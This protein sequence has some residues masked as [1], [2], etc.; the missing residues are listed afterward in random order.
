GAPQGA[1][2][3]SRH[4]GGA[5][6]ARRRPRPYASEQ[7][8]RAGVSVILDGHVIVVRL[9]NWLGDTVMALPA[10]AALR[11]AR[12]DALVT[13]VGPSAPLLAGQAGGAA[14]PRRPQG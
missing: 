13:A 5:G 8:C 3:P 11:A 10:L 4:G 14:P 2:R 7:S 6:R 1:L 12:P 9:P